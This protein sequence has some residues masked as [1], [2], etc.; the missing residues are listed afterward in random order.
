MKR[1]SEEGKAGDW[2]RRVWAIA[3]GGEDGGLGEVAS[4]WM[5]SRERSGECFKNSSRLRELYLDYLM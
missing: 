3:Q 1:G 5:E 4:M 2:T